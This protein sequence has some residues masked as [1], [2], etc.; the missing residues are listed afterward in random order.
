MLR[1]AGAEAEVS[2]KVRSFNTTAGPTVIRA[3]RDTGPGDADGIARGLGLEI[4]ASS[5]GLRDPA[6]ADGGSLEGLRGSS[7]TAAGG[8]L[9]ADSF[10]AFAFGAR[11]CFTGMAFSWRGMGIFLFAGSW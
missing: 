9:G 7:C 1:L 4:F 8:F 6:G 3:D 2:L 10:L 5:G 11:L